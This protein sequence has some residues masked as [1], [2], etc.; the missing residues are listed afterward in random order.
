MAQETL[1]ETVTA[2][3][4]SAREASFTT[5]RA[6]PGK[7][8][9]LAALLS[10]AAHSVREN[11]PETLQWLAL[12]ENDSQFAA[13]D[14]FPGGEARAAHHAR[15]SGD[16]LRIH[17]DELIEGGWEKGVLD[18]LLYCRV[19]SALVRGGFHPRLA[20]CMDIQAVPGRERHLAEFLTGLAAAI[21]KDEPSTL[22]WFSLRLSTSRFAAFSLFGNGSARA[23]H[24]AGRAALVL[25]ARAREWVQGGWD[26]GVLGNT[27]HYAVVAAAR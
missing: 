23:S 5:F 18:Q 11:E 17:A 1:V 6:R 27:T 10:E 4:Q 12:I 14:F 21:E 16:P 15:Q 2:P 24:L 7:E 3:L 9:R 22:Q 20:T 19:L 8:A 13:L 26:E 25:K